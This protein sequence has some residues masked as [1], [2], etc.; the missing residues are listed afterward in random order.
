[1]SPNY[2]AHFLYQWRPLRIVSW[3]RAKPAF[4][5]AHCSF[6]PPRFTINSP[7]P[8]HRP[9]L[10]L[11]RLLPAIAAW[12]FALLAI[13]L[14][15]SDTQRFRLPVAALA[16]QSLL[17]R[18]LISSPRLFFTSSAFWV[19]VCKGDPVRDHHTGC[20]NTPRYSAPTRSLSAPI[21]ALADST[22]QQRPETLSGNSF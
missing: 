1:M 7:R 22:V 21:P 14:P 10:S 6:T 20:P 16:D 15:V 17:C 9:Y 12:H 5:L 18:G 4:H 3:S 19:V 2:T 13:Q 8:F 11:C